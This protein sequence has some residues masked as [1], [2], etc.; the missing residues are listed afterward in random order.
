MLKNG[1]VLASGPAASSPDGGADPCALRRRR[2]RRPARHRPA[3]LVV[4]ARAAGETASREGASA[5][6]SPA[7]SCCSAALLLVA[8]IVRAARRLDADQPAARVRLVDP[9]RRQPGRADLLHRP[10]AAHARRGAGRL[11]ARGRR[12]RLPGSAAQ[13]AG[14]AVHAGRVGRRGARR[15]A[16]RSRSR[17]RC[18]WLGVPVAPLASFAGSLLAVGV[19]YLLATARHR[20]LSTN[21]LLLAGV[22][23]NAFFSALILFVQYFADF[24]ETFRILR[25]LMGDLDVS[26]YGPLVAT[27]PLVR[28]LVRGVRLAGAPAQPAQPRHRRRRDRAGSTSSARSASRSSARR[29]P[30]APRCRSAARSASSASSFRT[31]CG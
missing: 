28:R 22:T 3:S 24:A 7:L 8:L 9:V 2:R 27:L 14:H 13:S 15:D 6:E 5:G 23:M 16:R 19:V 25:W 1:R 21:T 26:S 10:A 31:W 4:P 12:R 17:R 11:D 29:W 18:A 30:P 20:G